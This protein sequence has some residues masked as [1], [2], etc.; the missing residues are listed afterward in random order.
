MEDQ[1]RRV[2]SRRLWFLGIGTAMIFVLLT[3]RLVWLQIFKAP[4]YAAKAEGNITRFIDLTPMRGDIIDAKGTLLV[5][6][7]PQFTLTV[8]WLDLQ[9]SK[10]KDWQAVI[11]ALAGY[12]KPYWPNPNESLDSIYED[13]LAISQNPQWGYRPVEVLSGEPEAMT[14]LRAIVAEHQNELPGVSVEVL[15]LRSYVSNDLAGQ[16]LGYVREVS[17]EELSQFNALAEIEAGGVKYQQGDLVGKQGVEKSYDFY[18]R[19][20]KGVQQIEVDNNAR[21]IRK[22][23]IQPAQPGKTVQLTIDADLQAAL[24]A[25]LDEQILEV[26]KN[27]PDSHAG[28]AVVLDVN[29]GKILAMASR[30]AMNPNDLIGLISEETA[31]RYFLDE[32]AASYNRA[33]SGTYAPGSTF[34]MLTAMA[35]LKAGVITPQEKIL[36]EMSSLG[37]LAAQQQGFPEWGNH[38]FGWVDLLY[39]LAQSSDIYFEVVGRRVFEA[40]PELVKQLCNEF[41][42]GVLSGVDLPGEAKGI[43]PSAEWKKENYI[44]LDVTLQRK[45]QLN[46]IETRYAAKLAQAADEQERQK[47]AKQKEA[48]IARVE[49]AYQQN[50]AR[51]KEW[52]LYDSFNNAIG[53]GYNDYTPLQLA[54]YV[55]TMVNG[56][57]RYRPYLV[58]KLLDP[59]SGE[60][61][62]ENQPKALN[63]VSVSPEILEV[64]KRGMS[65]V[66]SGD[67]TAKWL[68]GDMPEFTGGGKTGTAQLGSVHTISENQ[69]NGMFVAFAPYDQPQIAFAGVVEY[70]GHGSESSGYVAKAAF[71]QYFGW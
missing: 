52:K 43:A 58:D 55:A 48:D 39:G 67:G 63:T 50:L 16:L 54:Q 66:T 57:T 45:T 11:Y 65:G 28:A 44:P 17:E 49:T 2:Y 8:D 42:L 12:V 53:Q 27:Y 10:D 64:V 21:P 36:D 7:I 3:A 25:S 22:T 5:T 41:G 9:Q 37:S 14:P 18:L 62:L 6:S 46:D 4:V 31:Y 30:P 51:E 23:T 32:R 33:L 24:E 1:E 71:K 34:K 35:G 38:H 69:F 40:A 61:V 19:G 70:G 68:F 29:T 59:V 60:V 47:L 20:D 26:Q 15:P 13:I 56:G